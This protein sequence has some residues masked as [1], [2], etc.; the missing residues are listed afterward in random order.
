MSKETTKIYDNIEKSKSDK[1]N[2]QIRVLQNGLKA[3]LV[4][5]PEAEQSSAS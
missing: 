4:S 3:L 2:C 1:F 5:D